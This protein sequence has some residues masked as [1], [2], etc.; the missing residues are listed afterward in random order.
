MLFK[1]HRMRSGVDMYA[2]SGSVLKTLCRNEETNR[3]RDIKQGE[4]IESIWDE[5]NHSGTTFFYSK[6]D[7]HR[8]QSEGNLALRRVYNE[9]NK[10]PKKFFYEKADEL[11]DAI[12]FPEELAAK[13]A[14]PLDVGNPGPIE[15]WIA[16]FSLKGFIEG[17]CF[18]LDDESESSAWMTDSDAKDEDE[19]LDDDDDEDSHEFPEVGAEDDDGEHDDEHVADPA[20][21]DQEMADSTNDAKPEEK[22]KIGLFDIPRAAGFSDELQEVMRKMT[23]RER[24]PSKDRRN[25]A[26]MHSEFMDFL[27]K[28][29]AKG[30]NPPP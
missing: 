5:V 14:D 6:D 22:S 10:F 25:P 19:D 7:D 8:D 2:P 30:L 9:R 11:E 17:D 12:L 3:P 4:E 27:D 1:A 26:V 16:G 15:K 21:L 13:K 24:R 20:D 18:E 29:K 23:V 28:E